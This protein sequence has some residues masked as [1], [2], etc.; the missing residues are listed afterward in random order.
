MAVCSSCTQQI[1]LQSL[2]I[3]NP[4]EIPMIAEQMGADLPSHQCNDP[5]A[6]E[7]TCACNHAARRHDLYISTLQGRRPSNVLTE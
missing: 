1:V 7:C 3:L 2:G 6:S 4:Q 5:L